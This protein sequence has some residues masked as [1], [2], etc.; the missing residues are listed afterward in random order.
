MSRRLYRSDQDR[1]LGGICGGLG[2][3]LDA[4]PNII[5]I[6][7]VVFTIAALGTGVIV[8]IASWIILPRRGFE[9]V[10]DGESVQPNYSGDVAWHTLV[11]GAVLVMLGLLLLARHQWHWFGLGHLWPVA[12]VA[13]GIALIVQ[14]RSRRRIDDQGINGLGAS[15]Q[16]GGPVS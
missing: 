2:E 15:H 3:Y 7:A 13:L 5:R 6:L 4:D 14:A 8:Y 16:N 1:V 9:P 12:L 11:P 10:S